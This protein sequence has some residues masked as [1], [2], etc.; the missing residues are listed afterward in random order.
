MKRNNVVENIV[1]AHRGHEEKDEEI[2]P[3]EHLQNAGERV[4]GADVE[5]GEIAETGH[6]DVGRDKNANEIV[7][8]DGVLLVIENKEKLHPTL[9]LFALLA[10]QDFSVSAIAS[11]SQSGNGNDK[12]QQTGKEKNVAAVHFLCARHNRRVLAHIG[13]RHHTTNTHNVLQ[14]SLPF[15]ATSTQPLDSRTRRASLG[16]G[17]ECRD[18]RTD[19]GGPQIKHTSLHHVHFIVPLGRICATHHR[20]MSTEATLLFTYAANASTF[21]R[22]RIDALS[23]TPDSL[24]DKIV[25]AWRAAFAS[26]ASLPPPPPALHFRVVGTPIVLSA[27]QLLDPVARTRVSS[28]NCFELVS[29]APPPAVSGGVQSDASSSYLESVATPEVLD[30]LVL[31]KQQRID[32]NY[33]SDFA[34]KE[35]GFVSTRTNAA[36]TVDAVPTL[37]PV[38]PVLGLDCEMCTTHA[39]KELTRCTVVNSRGAVVFD[40]LCVPDLP[41]LDFHTR[42]SGIDKHSL[43][44]VS[45]KLADVQRALL[46]FITPAHVLVG[47]SLESDLRALKLVHDRVADTSV[48]FTFVFPLNDPRRGR[49]RYAKYSLR[50]L[51]KD[52]LGRTIQV[53]EA[54]DVLHDSCED[55]TAALDLFAVKVR[56]FIAANAAASSAG[57]KKR[58]VVEQPPIVDDNNDDNGDDDASTGAPPPTRPIQRVRVR[59]PSPQP[60]ATVIDQRALVPVRMR[61]DRDLPIVRTPDQFSARPQATGMFSSAPAT[62]GNKLPIVHL[63]PPKLRVMASLAPMLQRV[64]K[65][66]AVETAAATASGGDAKSAIPA[67]IYP[68][69]DVPLRSPTVPTRIRQ[70]FVDALLDVEV[71]RAPKRPLP[72]AD[73]VKLVNRVQT[74]E[75]S[76]FTQSQNAVTYRNLASQAL[77]KHRRGE[78][79]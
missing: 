13:P 21:V 44:G 65:A 63:P 28:D 27:M 57:A 33:P 30:A 35:L 32:N 12:E 17:K 10:I 1:G 71:A 18:P 9:P 79:W 39:G 47:H 46:S 40:S 29:S 36:A 41:V 74:L 22:V 55:A 53:N 77:A 49:R 20:P 42:Y 19:A 59:S 31:T 66:K 3:P 34:A 26:D 56:Q 11:L 23:D 2:E 14:H 50:Q 4:V 72:R 52:H 70:G 76:L 51:A 61:N 58:K 45:T 54:G 7:G 67:D 16:A 24:Y 69:I 48:L 64:D 5:E 60:T 78:H 37:A 68:V 62:T 73:A 75:Q 8:V 25:V 38:T 6:P 43:D 15:I